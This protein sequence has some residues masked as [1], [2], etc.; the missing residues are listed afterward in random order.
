MAY[1]GA[2]VYELDEEGIIER[3]YDQTATFMLFRAFME[4][5]ERYLRHLF[6]D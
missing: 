5:P 4:S 1:P 2:R 6:G 3:P